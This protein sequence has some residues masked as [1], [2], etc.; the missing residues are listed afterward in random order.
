M[1]VK[2]QKNQSI[3]VCQIDFM[4]LSFFKITLSPL[5]HSRFPIRLEHNIDKHLFFPEIPVEI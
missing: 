1:I 4:I 2:I 5:F 3:A